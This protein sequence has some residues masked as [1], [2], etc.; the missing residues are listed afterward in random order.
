MKEKKWMKNV[1]KKFQ[2]TENWVLQC[3]HCR[4]DERTISA[5][6]RLG[7]CAVHL[8]VPR[9]PRVIHT[10]SVWL[11]RR[12]LPELRAS[13]FSTASLQV[14][15][16][17]STMS[18]TRFTNLPL[19]LLLLPPHRTFFS[20]CLLWEVVVFLLPVLPLLVFLPWRVWIQWCCKWC[21]CRSPCNNNYCYNSSWCSNLLP[22]ACIV[23]VTYI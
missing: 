6:E 14:W 18:L 7:A 17:P 23:C 9:P 4:A 5:N 10:A 22:F 8:G 2:C 3:V 20:S 21:R 1:I 15:R 11:T 16:H 12:V 13:F 19:L